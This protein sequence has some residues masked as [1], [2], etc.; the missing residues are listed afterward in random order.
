MK[1][2]IRNIVL[3]A[4]A[5]AM[6]LSLTGCEGSDDTPEPINI[7]F[8][9]GIA[10][11]ET[12]LNDG[13]DE[14]VALP[15]IP[16]TDYAF[17]SAEGEPAVIGETGTIPDLS[18]RGYTDVMMERIQAGIQADLIEQLASYEPL[19]PELDMAGATEL[20]VRTLNAHAIKGRENI[21]V[22]YCSGRST[23]SFINMVET[24]IYELDVESSITA[25][26]QKMNVDMSD[27]DK[28][29]WYCCGDWM[30]DN[31]SKL[32][33]NEREKL[34]TFY[35]KLFNTLGAKSVTFKDALP[36]SECYHFATTPV[37]PIAVEGTES[38]LK[39][40]VALDPDIFEEADA[41][42]LEA[43][44]VI[45]EEQVRYKPDSSEFLDPDAAV[46]AIQPVADFLLEH[47]DVNILVYGTC[48]GDADTE[49]TLRLGRARSEAVKE[50]LGKAGIDESRITAVTVKV[51]DNPY[52]QAGLGIGADAS[53][54]RTCVIVDMSTELAQQILSKAL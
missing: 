13:I 5:L 17:I 30:G 23:T 31:Q 12:K 36:S 4:L 19:Y 45:P 25:V 9:V 52:H 41:R 28:I 16:G 35:E 15:A 11:G 53:V 39:D 42:A 10:D 48:A 3:A 26:T 40:L 32:S 18:D 51:S 2:F 21:L 44:I 38:G 8:V 20:A 22:F 46:A 14:F 54:N 34:K 7:A 27:I 1:K 47:P 6:F 50:I 24:P 37:S 29:I 43:P 49:Y 33:A